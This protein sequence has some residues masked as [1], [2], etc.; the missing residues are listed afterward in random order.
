MNESYNDIY[1]YVSRKT[2]FASLLMMCAFCLLCMF[3][4]LSASGGSKATAVSHIN[5][6]EYVAASASPSM[7]ILRSVD[8]CVAVCD[9]TDGVPIEILDVDIYSLPEDEQLA[10]EGGICVTSI[11]EL[12]A[13]IES[14]TS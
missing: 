7:Y 8:G 5:Q 1:K 10:L 4:A 13:T 9:F 12:V 11:S 3:T 2:F 6:D 14:Y